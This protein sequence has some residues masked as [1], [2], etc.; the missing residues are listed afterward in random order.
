MTTLIKRIVI[1]KCHKRC[2]KK[3]A[4]VHTT[5]TIGGEVVE[6][7]VEGVVFLLS[8]CGKTSQNPKTLEKQLFSFP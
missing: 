3:A 4:Q 1:V 5:F 7:V 6:V 8:L 2:K